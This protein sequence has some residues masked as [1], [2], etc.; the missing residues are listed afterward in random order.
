MDRDWVLA[1][2]AASLETFF[3]RLQDCISRNSIDPEDMWNFDE[4]VS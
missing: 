4:R 1:M 3:E 2:N